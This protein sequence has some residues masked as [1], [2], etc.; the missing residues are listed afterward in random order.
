MQPRPQHQSFWA[1]FAPRYSLRALVILTL[2]CCALLG[3]Y[4]AGVHRAR[5]QAPAVA[6]LREM[7]ATV[8]YDGDVGQQS[9]QR[10]G[11]VTLAVDRPSPYPKWAID[12]LSVDF[13]HNATKVK[14]QSAR[15]LPEAERRR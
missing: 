13:F 8:L 11:R 15:T 9:I 12:R 1:R 7:G 4:S 5:R 6:I 2:V 10:F 3:V 14:F